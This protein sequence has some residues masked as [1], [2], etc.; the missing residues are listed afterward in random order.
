[1]GE[2]GGGGD[3]VHGCLLPHV[4]E[5]HVHTWWDYLSL[6]AWSGELRGPE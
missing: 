3:L 2:E 5:E 6:A 4:S 1:M